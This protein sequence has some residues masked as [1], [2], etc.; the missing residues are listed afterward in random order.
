L[1]SLDADAAGGMLNTT[2]QNG[3]ALSTNRLNQN[4]LTLTGAGSKA[5]VRPDGTLPSVLT[6]F[7][8]GTGTSLDLTDNDLIVRAN[9]ASVGTLYAALRGQIISAQ[10]GLDANFLTRWDGSG[11]TSS[12]ARATNV[13]AGLDLVALGLIRNN[14]LDIATGVPGSAYTSFG[15]VNVGLHDLL[16]KYTYTGDGNLDGAVTFDDYAAMDSAFFGSIPNVGWATGDINFDNVVNFD[17]YAVVDQAFFQQGAAVGAAPP[18][19]EP[20]APA[21]PVAASGESKG[22]VSFTVSIAAS[23]VP[24]EDGSVLKEAASSISLQTAD[25]LIESAA[26]LQAADSLADQR[27]ATTRKANHRDLWDAAILSALD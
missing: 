1:V 17:D 18:A 4:G 26:I 23:E 15:G 11:L 2:V 9:E 3:A 6:S 12:S 13:A 8:F 10:N 19:G 20:K 25:E 7:S 27:L 16:V 21:P 24:A 5:I 22:P 14:D